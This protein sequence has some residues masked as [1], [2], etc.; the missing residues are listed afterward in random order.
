MELISETVC[1]G[2][3]GEVDE[4]PEGIYFVF[5]WSDLSER[6]RPGPTAQL[7]P[8]TWSWCV[9]FFASPSDQ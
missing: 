4:V 5:W 6:G 7:R 9:W 8:T 2:E 3:T 1:G